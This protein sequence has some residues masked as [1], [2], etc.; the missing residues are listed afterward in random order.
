MVDHAN[1]EEANAVNMKQRVSE[2]VGLKEKLG[3]CISEIDFLNLKYQQVKSDKIK[4]LE[5]AFKSDNPR[6]TWQRCFN[7]LKQNRADIKNHYTLAEFSFYYWFYEKYD[8]RF[9]RVKKA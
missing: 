3:T 8:D 2:V 6:D 7:I 1:A 9:Y 5:C 4:N